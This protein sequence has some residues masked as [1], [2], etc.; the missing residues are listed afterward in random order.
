ME[1]DR[2]H[3][4]VLHP[5]AP[6]TRPLTRVINAGI[7]GERNL[8]QQWAVLGRAL[9]EFGDGANRGGELIWN[10]LMAEHR[11]HYVAGNYAWFELIEQSY[12]SQEEVPAIG[13]PQFG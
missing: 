9:A 13:A 3:I 10:F 2:S 12:P 4:G 6:L 11:R 7:L 8:A 5:D 1:G